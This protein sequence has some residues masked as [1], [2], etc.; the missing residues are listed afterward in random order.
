MSGL[1]PSGKGYGIS[2]S[3]NYTNFTVDEFK[4]K[5]PTADDVDIAIDCCG[6]CGSD[7]HTITG[8]WGPMSV[9]WC[10]PGHEII[11]KVT[12]VGA[13]VTEFKVGDRVG[14]G[15]Q[16]DSC[17]KCSRCKSDNEQYCPEQL[18][19]YNAVYP[20]GV[21][22]QGGYSTAIRTHQ[23]FVFAIP[24][25]ISSEE[26]APM[27]CAG[28]TVYSPLVRHG[29]GPGKT[30]GVIGIGG[31]GHLAIQFAKALGAKVVVFSH[32]PSKKE[33]C[34]KL[35]ADEF[36][37]TS[38]KDFAKPWF[39]KIDYIISAADAAAIP[40]DQFMTTLKIGAELT[41]VGLPDEEWKFKPG[42]MQ[43][44]MTAIGCSHIGSK[45][46]A[47]EMFK[48]AA[49]KGVRPIIDQVLPMKDAAIAIEGVKN[50]KV[51]YRYVLKNDLA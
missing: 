25:V 7:V 34:L 8:G 6:V 31:L 37:V 22:A 13:N 11:G 12:H 15:A 47:N 18:D 45:K 44:N 21:I 27:L 19:T 38:E 16:V 39:D 41:S 40:L 5:T 29:T 36:I 1:L 35:G 10:V 32:S 33:D 50:N 9:D 26:A 28:L 2:D 46:E 14:V 48:L 20:D 23:Q 17:H 30:V 43:G 3:K 24:D 4:L 51:R 49:E 42:V